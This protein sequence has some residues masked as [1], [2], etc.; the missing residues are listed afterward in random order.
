MVENVIVEK[1]KEAKEGKTRIVMFRASKQDRP[2]RRGSS[3]LKR[4]YS[5]ETRCLLS[6]FAT[7]FEVQRKC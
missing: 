4:K 6:K 3:V 5:A 7:G 2:N 1:M